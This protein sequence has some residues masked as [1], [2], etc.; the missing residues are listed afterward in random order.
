[1][2]AISAQIV[3]LAGMPLRTVCLFVLRREGGGERAGR[4]KRERGGGARVEKKEFVNFVFFFRLLPLSE[5]FTLSLSLP[6]A[7]ASLS[8]SPSPPLETLRASPPSLLSSATLPLQLTKALEVQ[9]SQQPRIRHPRA[10]DQVAK[11]S[12]QLAGDQPRPQQLRPEARAGKQHAQVAAQGR[13]GDR[14]RAQLQRAH[15]GLE[16]PPLPEGLAA[17]LSEDGVGE[18]R[19]VGDDVEDGGELVYRRGRRETRRR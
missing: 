18:E 10:L 14:R 7:R 11:G 9:P 1:M 13:G 6:P 19:P 16:P 17:A 12:G 8:L 15:R 2:Y 4:G 3:S 5:T